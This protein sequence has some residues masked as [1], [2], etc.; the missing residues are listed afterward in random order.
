[1]EESPD[2]VER[3]GWNFL[4]AFGAEKGRNG[5]PAGKFA[6]GEG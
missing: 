4:E 2:G 5:K 1:M 6:C 3:S